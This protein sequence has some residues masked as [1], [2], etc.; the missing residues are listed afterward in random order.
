MIEL[1]LVVTKGFSAFLTRYVVSSGDS[2]LDVEGYVSTSPTRFRGF[3]CVL[4]NKDN[5]ANVAED[6]ALHFSQYFRN[7][8]GVL[9]YIKV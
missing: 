7:I 5:W 1:D 3:S 9:F 4:T 8:H 2:H 6:I